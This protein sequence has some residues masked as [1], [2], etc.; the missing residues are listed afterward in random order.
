M[1]KLDDRE[2]FVLII[3][4]LSILVS[5]LALFIQYKNPIDLK[6][7]ISLK[8][9]RSGSDLPANISSPVLILKSEE[10][11]SELSSIFE[12]DTDFNKNSLILLSLGQ[13]STGGYSIV[14]N[15]LYLSNNTLIIN[16]TEK[17]PGKGCYVAQAFTS[18]YLLLELNVKPSDIEVAWSTEKVD[19][20]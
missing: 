2:K 13:R 7:T 3:I 11:P 1:N 17:T 12:N 18:P 16:A 4:L 5:A 20:S 6:E 19:C 8:E 9:L 15:N 10:I 14:I